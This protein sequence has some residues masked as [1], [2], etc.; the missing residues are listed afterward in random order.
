[1]KLRQAR[2]IFAII[3]TD[4]YVRAST[5]YRAIRRMEKTATSKESERYWREVIM[6]VMMVPRQW[7]RDECD[8]AWMTA[9]S[10]PF[11]AGEIDRIVDFVTGDAK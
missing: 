6:P 5:S 8:A 9:P 7:T 2:K 11:G 4:R 3:G 10:I 1:M